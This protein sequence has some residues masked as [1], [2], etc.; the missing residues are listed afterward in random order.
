MA[1]SLPHLPILNALLHQAQGNFRGFHTPGHQRGQGIHP[2][3]A[4]AWR[5][6]GLQLDLS[7]I[8]GL[9]NLAAPTGII[10]QAQNLA[11]E[12]FGAEKTWFLINGST[13]GISA[14]IMATCGP[15]DRIL[16]PRTIHQSVLSGMILAGARPVLITP[17]YD[18]VWGLALPLNSEQIQA[19]LKQYPDTKAVLVISPTYDGLCPDLVQ[20][21][22][23]VHQQNIP[24]IVDEA[25]GSHFQFHPQLP[26]SAIQAGADVVIHSTHKTLS[27]FTQAAM[28]HHQGR[29]VSP[30]RISQCLRVLQSSSP[31][32]LLLASLDVAREQ[33]A[34]EGE[35]LWAAVL[36]LVNDLN[37]ALD[38][39]PSA[40]Q[41]SAKFLPEIVTKDP[42][43]V[44]LG[45]W[46]LKITGYRADDYL[47]ESHH[48]I[49]ELPTLN[50]L[51][52]LL[53]L[54]HTRADINALVQSWGQLIEMMAENHGQKYLYTQEW[55]TLN[56]MGQISSSLGPITTPIIDPRTAFLGLQQQVPQAQAINQIS[57]EWICPYPPGIPWLFPGEV[58]TEPIM[59]QLLAIQQAGGTI[60]GAS[61]PTLQTLRI[62]EI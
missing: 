35:S 10:D 29:R 1:D 33:M 25:H 50:Y 45:T 38:N 53:G 6:A 60:T 12:T 28:L 16:I 34:T 31:S 4:D 14:A 42:T 11:A 32:Y 13:V 43:R 36:G 37:Q 22:E 19:A 59:A 54:G 7:E 3:L 48:L 62:I 21:V 40:I 41:L 49:G 51:T 30:T 23:V 27:A 52:F 24:L 61:D 39:L 20:T 15:G 55:Q 46:P 9:D 2:A 26:M 17:D 18:P 5:I 44:T 47:T 56:Q 57:A 8:P 58:I